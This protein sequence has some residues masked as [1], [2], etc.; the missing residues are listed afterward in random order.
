MTSIEYNFNNSTRVYVSINENVYKDCKWIARYEEFTIKVNITI[1]DGNKITSKEIFQQ[2]IPDLLLDNPSSINNTRECIIALAKEVDDYEEFYDFIDEY[3]ASKD[4]PCT[5]GDPDDCE[6]LDAL[7]NDDIDVKLEI[8]GFEITDNLIDEYMLDK[9]EEMSWI[10]IDKN[11]IEN[12]HK[13]VYST[14]EEWINQMGKS[15]ILAER[16]LPNKFLN[17]FFELDVKISRAISEL[18]SI[19]DKVKEINRNENEK[20]YVNQRRGNWAIISHFDYV[21]EYDRDACWGEGGVYNC[22]LCAVEDIDGERYEKFHTFEISGED[23]YID[24]I[25]N[26]IHDKYENLISGIIIVKNKI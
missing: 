4:K 9:F 5:C 18:E 8:I 1:I 21:K 7:Y 16:I 25:L 17:R 10:G 23:V 20:Y 14:R 12:M 24:N 26:R 3:R 6:C 15:K 13:I 11:E 2:S 19:L 22:I